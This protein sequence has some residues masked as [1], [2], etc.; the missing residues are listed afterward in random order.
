MVSDSSRMSPTTERHWFTSRKLLL[1]F[2]VLV[3]VIAV[4]VW[5]WG[6]SKSPAVSSDAIEVEAIGENLASASSVPK[7]LLSPKTVEQVTQVPEQ[8]STTLDVFSPERVIGNPKC[9]VWTGYGQAEDV[10]MVIL[11]GAD[12]SRF[13]VLDGAGV[14]FH[15][16]LPFLHDFAQIGRQHDGSVV[17]GFAKLW[18]NTYERAEEDEWV[19]WNGALGPVRV[20]LD[21]QIIFES[22]KASDFD[23]ALNGSSFF[24]IEP[25]ASGVSNLR[26]HNL[27]QGIEEHHHLDQIEP[28]ES[29]ESRYI[30][31]YTTR[32][33]EV[34]LAAI[35]DVDAKRWFYPVD[36]GMPQV[37]K[38]DEVTEG[39]FAS[40]RHGYFVQQDETRDEVVVFKREFRH[41]GTAESMGTNLWSRTLDLDEF[42]GMQLSDDGVWL[43]LHAWNL[44]ML[45]A[46]TGET[47]F[48]FPA[49]A[50]LSR[51][52][53]PDVSKGREDIYMRQS[54]MYQEVASKRLA[55]VL[56]ADSRLGSFGHIVHTLRVR[57]GLLIMDLGTFASGG[58]WYIYDMSEL[59]IDSQ[60]KMRFNTGIGCA[61]GNLPGQ[62]LQEVDGRLTYLTERLTFDS[63]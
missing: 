35:D 63:D 50:N 39:V 3:V 37:R 27:E 54:E 34:Q 59:Q 57:D 43:I 6:W 12:G 19:G 22:A 31:Y 26:I 17:V 25:L 61:S 29:P 13:A 5:R 28:H 38:M 4:L 15:G 58:V 14:V 49:E 62:G 48:A 18:G 20:Y 45:N 40:S 23:V 7:K 53:G 11:P 24:V 9:F 42:S 33:T 56:P 44:H 32:Q 8:P 52:V 2:A 1:L 51:L 60:P 30:A 46:A 41:D 21:G 36:G 16:E 55:N 10:A 47:A